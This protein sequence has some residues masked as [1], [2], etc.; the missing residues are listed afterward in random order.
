MRDLALQTFKVDD[1]VH[2]REPLAVWRCR[3]VRLQ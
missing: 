2:V 1:L 3:D